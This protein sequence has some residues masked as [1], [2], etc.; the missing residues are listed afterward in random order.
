MQMNF[1]FALW[2]WCS[3]SISC[4]PGHALLMEKVETEQ[5]HATTP[6]ALLHSVC[7]VSYRSGPGVHTQGAG[8]QRSEAFLNTFQFIL[9]PRYERQL[10]DIWS[11]PKCPWYLVLYKTPIRHL[12]HK[13]F[14]PCQ[15]ALDIYRAIWT[16]Q[17]IH[18]AFGS[19]Q[20]LLGI[21]SYVD[22]SELSGETFGPCQK[23]LDIWSC[24]KSL[25]DSVI[26][27]LPAMQETQA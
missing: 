14:G 7:T 19:C 10:T 9:T 27:N 4:C 25:G 6:K 26:K 2:V 23:F 8:W 22:L 15:K 18:K 5:H 1:R 3:P 21:W 13:T 20:K 12:V 24:P 17:S 11:C 16:L